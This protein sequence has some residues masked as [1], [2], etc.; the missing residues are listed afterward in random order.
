MVVLQLIKKFF[1]IYG[2]ATLFPQVKQEPSTVSSLLRSFLRFKLIIHVFRP[3]SGPFSKNSQRQRVL[4]EK[5]SFR[6]K[7]LLFELNIFH[8]YWE[9]ENGCKNQHLNF[10][11]HIGILRCNYSPGDRGSHNLLLG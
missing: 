6:S 9:K 3:L 8:Y 10:P 5:G 1:S 2:T 11:Y 7:K 4:L